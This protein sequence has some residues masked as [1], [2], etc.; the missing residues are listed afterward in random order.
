MINLE[1]GAKVKVRLH[2]GEVVEAAYLEPHYASK[3]RVKKSHLVE[4]EGGQICTAGKFSPYHPLNPFM[5]DRVR[6]VG[7]SCVLVPVGV[8]D[9]KNDLL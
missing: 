1:K 8:S 4:I 3:V 6:F 2:T 9:G 7:P 5:N